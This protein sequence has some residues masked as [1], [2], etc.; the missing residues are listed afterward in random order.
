MSLTSEIRDTI[1]ALEEAWSKPDGFLGK[2]RDGIYLESEG[3]ALLTLLR[4]I[5]PEGSSVDRRL[6]SL[7]WYLSIFLTW[8]TERLVANGVDQPTYERFVNQVH[9]ELERV[10]GIP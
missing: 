10:L 9:S 6:V 2:A 4:S 3:A 7:L 1:N 8:Q 5:R